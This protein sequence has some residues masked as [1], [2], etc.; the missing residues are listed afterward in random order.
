MSRSPLHQQLS[1]IAS[2]ARFCEENRL[3]TDEGIARLAE[4]RPS[5]RSILRAGALGAGSM[6]LSGFAAPIGVAR[7]SRIAIV[8]GG[9]AGLVCADRL[10]AKGFTATIY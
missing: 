8:G 9:L 6:L 4:F 10:Q 2:I 3:P 7:G 5:R 1:R